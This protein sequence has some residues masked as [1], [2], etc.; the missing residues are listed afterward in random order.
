MVSNPSYLLESFLLYIHTLFCFILSIKPI[1]VALWFIIAL[2]FSAFICH[3][4][5]FFT[6]VFLF[7]FFLLYDLFCIKCTALYHQ[8]TQKLNQG[9]AASVLHKIMGQDHFWRSKLVFH[10]VFLPFLYLQRNHEFGF[11]I[12]VLFLWNSVCSYLQNDRKKVISTRTLH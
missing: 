10:E 11:I 6:C 7:G 3:V 5:S 12:Q 4:L 2:F 9:L 1:G 8:T